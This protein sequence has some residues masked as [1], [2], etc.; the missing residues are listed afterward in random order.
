MRM[1][2]RMHC[3]KTTQIPQYI[4]EAHRQK[5]VVVCQ[6]RRLAATAVAERIA[7]ETNTPLG[8]RVGYMVKGAV[9]ATTTTQILFLTYGV[10]L[11][12]IQEDPALQAIDCVILDE[13]HGMQHLSISCST[14]PHTGPLSLFCVLTLLVSG[15]DLC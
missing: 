8:Q 4:V 10:L 5:R 14:F 11:R 1:C 2:V 9:Q 15:C 6:P 12:R 13:V 7:Q 3:R